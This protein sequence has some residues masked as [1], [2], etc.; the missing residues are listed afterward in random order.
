MH[1]CVISAGFKRGHASSWTPEFRSDYF[2][3]IKWKPSSWTS[4]IDGAR[5]A[6][7]A[8]YTAMYNQRIESASLL[9]CLHQCSSSHCPSVGKVNLCS[10]NL[11]SFFQGSKLPLAFLKRRRQVIPPDT[12]KVDT[13]R[14]DT[15][16]AKAAHIFIIGHWS[17][18]QMAT[19]V[20]C[21]SDEHTT[22]SLH[23]MTSLQPSTGIWDLKATTIVVA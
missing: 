10:T 3:L 23:F 4:R 15:N 22:P 2:F 14:P 12:N 7:M 5:P 17:T 21:Q 8:C 1:V 9:H 20:Y 13:T 16:K 6:A 19:T 11:S 18:N